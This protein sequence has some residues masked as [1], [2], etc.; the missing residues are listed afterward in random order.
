MGNSERTVEFL[1]QCDLSKFIQEDLNNLTRSV[2]N[3]RHGLM[4]GMK[5]EW[6]RSQ[7]G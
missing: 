7:S 6:E 4:L 3:K 2:T 1:D 5:G